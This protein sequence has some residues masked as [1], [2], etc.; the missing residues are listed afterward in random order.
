MIGKRELICISNAMMWGARVKESIE[1][2]VAKAGA[3]SRKRTQSACMTLV[4]TPMMRLLFLAL[5]TG[6]LL[7]GTAAYA[8]CCCCGQM[9]GQQVT[10]P[11]EG[12]KK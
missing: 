2:L 6:N 5:T 9:N 12:V 7:M 3:N 4:N 10:T 11:Q 8:Q 1:S